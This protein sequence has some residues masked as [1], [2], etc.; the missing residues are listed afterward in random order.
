MDLAVSEALPIEAVNSAADFFVRRIPDW[1]AHLVELHRG[2]KATVYRPD[3]TLFL[4]LKIGRLSE[5]D[6]HD[7]VTL[8]DHCDR[9]AEHVAIDDVLQALAALPAT[10]DEALQRR[11][12][13]LRSRLLQT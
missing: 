7:C 6:L 5:V 12:E 1:R 2:A 13:G 9:T 10:D 3:A 4:R 8:L 11:R